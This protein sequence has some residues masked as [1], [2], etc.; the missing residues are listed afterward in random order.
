MMTE[1]LIVC[2]LIWV[3]VLLYQI[4]QRGFLILIVW[5]FI[6]P[7][8]SNVVNRPGSNPFLEISAVE[9]ASVKPEKRGRGYI[10][11]ETTIRLGE[12]LEPNRLLFGAYLL[13]FGLH[14]FTLRR[15]PVPLDRTEKWMAVFSL[16]LVASALLQSRRTAFSLRVATDA[17]IVP[18]LSYMV[19]RRFVTTEDRL[20]K[21][22]KVMGYM[23]FYV[24]LICFIER[25]IHPSIT[26]R[27]SGPFPKRDALY[28]VMMV[29]F[30]A[31]LIDWVSSIWQDKKR[32]LPYGIQI[33][34]LTLVP[35]IVFFTWTRG[36][37]LGFLL[38][39]WT[40]AFLGRKLVMWRPKL[41]IIGL[42]LFL[43]PVTVLGVQELLGTEEVYSRVAN[44]R[45]VYGR[46]ATYRIMV[47]E[48][49]NNPVFGI[50][51]NNV[52]D[53]LAEEK[54][55]AYGMRSYAFS[56]NSYLSLGT[57]L[58]AI[59][60]IA[61]LVVVGSMVGAGVRIHRM[62]KHPQDRWRGIGVVA[63]M[64]AY[65]IPAAF[66]STLYQ[67]WVSHVYVFAY[68]GAIAGLYFQE[69]L[70]KPVIQ[71]RQSRDSA[72]LTSSGVP[73]EARNSL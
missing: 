4:G 35:V 30:F 62:G 72:V 37:W 40:F 7:V 11:R 29:V 18:F 20:G 1:L 38:G 27:L 12:L 9:E 44:I 24:V 66:D 32:V 47:N 26:Y 43:F 13:V 65:L 49:S 54:E 16:I 57:E 19:A 5:L 61:Y 63:I 42:V 23:G 45:N 39:I 34:V 25:V 71:S 3:P 46:L 58:G 10:T 55:S 2:S 28:I 70:D 33:C 64:I 69:P 21:L 56:H 8:A 53:L 15:L 6:A 67:A 73:R 50:G 48:M 36:I 17:F 60:I 68:L 22:M 41:L 59:G 14:A 52:R 51:L 31:V